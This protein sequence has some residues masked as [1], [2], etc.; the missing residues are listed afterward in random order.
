MDLSGVRQLQGGP[1]PTSPTKSNQSNRSCRPTFTWAK[2]ARLS[3]CCW[4]HTWF[5]TR[6][7]KLGNQSRTPNQVF[8][9]EPIPDFWPVHFNSEIYRKLQIKF[10]IGQYHSGNI[11][12]WLSTCPVQRR[13][14]RVISSGWVIFSKG[15][16]VKAFQKIFSFQK[17]LALYVCLSEKEMRQRSSSSQRFLQNILS[18]THNV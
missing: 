2:T 18:I 8:Y 6:T 16:L 4:P 14:C 17:G 7:I 12:C 5:L 13:R 3:W 10:F 11:I 9:A 15:W 1:S